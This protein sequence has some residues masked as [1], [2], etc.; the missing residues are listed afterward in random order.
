MGSIDVPRGGEGND[1]EGMDLVTEL[2]YDLH[3]L[4]L[5]EHTLNEHG[6]DMFRFAPELARLRDV[7]GPDCECLILSFIRRIQLN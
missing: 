4:G 7:I 1:E 6:E 5:V 2:L 3:R